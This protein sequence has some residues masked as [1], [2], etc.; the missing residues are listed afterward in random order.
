MMSM[1][2]KTVA[3]DIMRPPKDDLLKKI[4][5]SKLKLRE[6]DIVAISSKVVSIWEGGT[7]L[8]SGTD[9]KKELVKKEAEYYFETKG[10]FPA[11]FTIKNNAIIRSGGIDE[12]NGNGYYVLWPKYPK[13]TANKLLKWLK[14]EYGIKKLGI[15]ITD[16]FSVPFRRGAIGFALSY[17]GFHPLFDYRGKPDIFGRKLIAEQMNVG[18][19]LA[20]AAVVEMGEGS[21]QTPIAVIRNGPH[22]EFSENRKRKPFS[23]FEV[24][25]RE[26]IFAP[27]WQKVKW[28]KGGEGKR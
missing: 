13:K 20:A 18:D 19:A 11:I 17:A 22:L 26:D 16:S 27:F 15:I 1:Q 28:K 12:S 23:S 3:I 25:F 21:E 5:K 7:I 14:Q 8:V 9:S 2:V 24:D 6:G 10:R 4:K